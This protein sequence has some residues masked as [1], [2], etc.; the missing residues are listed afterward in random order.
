MLILL[1][2]VVRVVIMRFIAKATENFTSAK[3]TPELKT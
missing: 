1:F 2:V 3:D